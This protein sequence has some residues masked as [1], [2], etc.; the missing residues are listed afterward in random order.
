MS[1]VHYNAPT[2]TIA[3]GQTASGSIGQATIKAARGI[4]IFAPSTL[5]E[6]VY[7]TVSN[8]GGSTY[9]TLQS[10]GNDVTIGAGKALIID[11]VAFNDLR[12]LAGGAVAASRAFTT[13]VI[14]E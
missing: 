11:S 2:L 8:D 7:V 12:L 5:P 14:E 6:T 10:G 1:R 4:A 3:N 9:Q 13:H